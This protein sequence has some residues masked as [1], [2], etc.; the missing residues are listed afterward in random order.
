MRLKE[1]ILHRLKYFWFIYVL[2]RQCGLCQG[3]NGHCNEC[4]EWKNLYKRD[5][6]RDKVRR[7]K[8]PTAKRREREY[9]K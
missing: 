2:N 8:Y 5:W 4:N 3:S 7:K 1:Y 6:K 9:W